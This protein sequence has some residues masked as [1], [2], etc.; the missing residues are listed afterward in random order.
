MRE[1]TVSE[2]VEWT[3]FLRERDVRV[4]KL[5]AYLA[6][7]TAAVYRANG[8]KCKTDDFILRLQTAVTARRPKT[9]EEAAERAKLRH[10]VALGAKISKDG[11]LKSNPAIARK[12]QGSRGP[13]GVGEP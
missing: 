9:R 12:R 7:L 8:G 10:A 4:E 13:R 11:R 3:V 2:L 1:T 6:Q 5:D